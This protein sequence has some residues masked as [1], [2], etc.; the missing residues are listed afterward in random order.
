MTPEEKLEHLKSELDC[1]QRRM[2]ILD[3]KRRE[4]RDTLLRISGAI[5]VLDE[6][7]EDSTG[8]ERRDDIPVEVTS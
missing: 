1:G 3:H 5:Q 7:A 6:L 8:E 2:E 4:L